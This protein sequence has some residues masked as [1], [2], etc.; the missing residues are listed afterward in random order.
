MVVVKPC[1][2][3][4]SDQQGMIAVMFWNDSADLRETVLDPNILDQN[5]KRIMNLTTRQSQL[6]KAIAI[7]AQIAQV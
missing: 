7:K 2:E 3:L 1:Y 6:D 5:W 4:S